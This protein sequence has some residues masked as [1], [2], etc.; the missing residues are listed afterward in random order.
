MAPAPV[1]S[2]SYSH[3]S[4]KS[5][6]WKIQLLIIPDTFQKKKYEWENQERTRYMILEY[7]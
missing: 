3:L 6:H 5:D 1:I 7:K 2:T 4:A